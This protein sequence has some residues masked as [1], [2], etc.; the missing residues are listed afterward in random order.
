MRRL[1]AMTVRGRLALMVAG[2]SIAAC[3]RAPDTQ[4][5]AA[6]AP[7]P[8]P[9]SSYAL[10]VPAPAPVMFAPEIISTGDFE[11]HP[12]FMPDGNTLY[13]VKS[14]P[15]FT[16]W[17]I[18]QSQFAQQHWTRP[19]IAPF[20]GRYR[21]ADPFITPDGRHFYFISDRP[22]N[23]EPKADMDIWRMDLTPNGWSEAQNLGEP[24]NSPQS[25]WH[26]SL[27]ATGVLYFGSA[28]PGGLGLTDLYRATR[29][30]GVW[31]VET[32]GAPINTAAD[33]YE[34]F[35]APDE[36]YVIF[37][38][39]RPDA[40]GASD[41]YLSWHTAGAWSAPL[42]LGAPL[43]SPALDLAPGISPDGRYFFFSSTR[44]GTGETQPRALHSGNGLGDIYQM[45]LS[46][47]LNAVPPPAP[48]SAPAK[49]Q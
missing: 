30:N 25:E 27:T 8:A 1:T 49:N 13:F 20:S 15:A 24:V 33:E 35:I 12:T 45:D 21:D 23:G 11:S 39:F 34:P 48:A 18:Y 16:R 17:T 40:L 41:L 6:A 14:D 4:V 28:R 9:V 31:Q 3:S 43:N 5:E 2:L 29:S 19:L 42:N 38:A 47:V 7:V 36:S 26:P 46:A 22:V 32:L 10:A 44:G 37:M